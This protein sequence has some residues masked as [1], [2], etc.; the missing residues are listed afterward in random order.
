[1]PVQTLQYPGKKQEHRK[2]EKVLKWS[3]MRT[4]GNEIRVIFGGISKGK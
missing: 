2:R 3:V 4:G 1:M